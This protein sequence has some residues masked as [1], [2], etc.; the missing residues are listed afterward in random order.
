MLSGEKDIMGKAYVT[1]TRALQEATGTSWA[2]SSWAGSSWAGSS[3][4]GSSWAGSSWAGGV[5]QRA[6]ALTRRHGSN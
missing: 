1:G 2:G 5:G 4:S 6:L 3:W